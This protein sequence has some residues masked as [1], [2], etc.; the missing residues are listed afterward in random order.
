MK[1]AKFPAI[2][3]ASVSARWRLKKSMKASS[4]SHRSCIRFSKT[5]LANRLLWRRR[6]DEQDTLLVRHE[7]LAASLPH[8]LRDPR[9][10]HEFR[11]AAQAADAIWA[12]RKP[13][14]Q[15]ADV[16]HA[17]HADLVAADRGAVCDDGCLRPACRGQRID[18]LPR[19]RHQ[20]SDDGPSR[21]LA[22]HY[23]RMRQLRL[24]QLRRAA[25]YAQVGESGVS[26]PGRCGAKKYSEIASAQARG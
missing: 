12:I 10:H 15:D 19:P 8:D 13:G 21:I 11:R 17:G 22:G 5:L 1:L 20:L 16:F 14:R 3:S 2:I 7:R 6:V 24:P 23:P 25:F 4:A 26:E 9:R 18:R